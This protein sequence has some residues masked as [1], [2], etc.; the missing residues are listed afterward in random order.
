M[1]PVMMSRSYGLPATM[2]LL[3]RGSTV[4]LKLMSGVPSRLVPLAAAVG[5]VAVG[6]VVGVGPVGP[7]GP[8][9]RGVV[10]VG[11]PGVVPV[12]PRKSC[13]R[14]VATLLASALLSWKIFTSA[15]SAGTTSRSLITLINKFIDF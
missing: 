15:R 13:C 6:P 8:V 4:M 7:V 1:S 5:V 14:I 11:P 3:V 9:G 10:G 12:V 2:M